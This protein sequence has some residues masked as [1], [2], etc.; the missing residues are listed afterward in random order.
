MLE[1]FPST[2]SSNIVHFSSLLDLTTEI[3]FTLLFFYQGAIQWDDPSKHYPYPTATLSPAA[4]YDRYQSQVP[5][6]PSIAYKD[7][8][9]NQ[10]TAKLP[11]VQEDDNQNQET[12]NTLSVRRSNRQGSM[13]AEISTAQKNGNHNQE[14]TNSLTVHRS[15]TQNL[16]ADD[17]SS[18]PSFSWNQLTRK[19]S[20]T[21]GDG[22]QDQESLLSAIL[23]HNGSVNIQTG[24]TYMT[25]RDPTEFFGFVAQEPQEMYISTGIQAQSP[26]FNESQLQERIAQESVNA[27]KLRSAQMKVSDSYREIKRFRSEYSNL[28]DSM[29]WMDQYLDT[30]KYMVDNLVK[31]NY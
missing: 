14:T 24:N 17:S 8:H 18:K 3:L 7:S 22:Y 4:R 15:G 16:V 1:I 28:S 5:A 10:A 23:K 29:K 20:S 13:T 9:P 26:L 25:N 2:K 11:T 30:I 12:I 19:L 21:Q 6:N 27:D 31:P